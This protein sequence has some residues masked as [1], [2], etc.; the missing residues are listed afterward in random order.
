MAGDIG[1]MTAAV[2]ILKQ[3]WAPEQIA[4]TLAHHGLHG[5]ADL[6]PEHFAA[7]GHIVPGHG[8]EVLRVP[9]SDLGAVVIVPA[10]PEPEDDPA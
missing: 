6:T 4:A 8:T 2:E 5:G 1:V 7:A 9:A 10:P 3:H